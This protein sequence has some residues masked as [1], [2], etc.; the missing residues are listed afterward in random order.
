MREA[1]PDF[2]A[3]RDALAA[4]AGG[5]LVLLTDVPIRSDGDR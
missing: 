2:W 5:L 1:P 4:A 3:A